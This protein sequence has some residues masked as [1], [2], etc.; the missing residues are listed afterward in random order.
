VALDR[1]ES[2]EIPP[3]Q[4]EI[5]GYDAGKK[6]I[7]RKPHVLVNTLGFLLGIPVTGAYVQDR[8]G[9]PDLLNGILIQ[10]LQR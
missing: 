8:D 2:T 10:V 3:S 7:G 9:A 6:V 4:A 5:C 1:S